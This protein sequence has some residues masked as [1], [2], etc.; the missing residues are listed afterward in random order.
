M[1]AERFLELVTSQT[2][3]LDRIMAVISSIDPQAPT[4]DEIVAALDELSEQ[5]DGTTPSAAVASVFGGRG[6]GGLGFSGNAANYYD[7]RNSMIHHVLDR[8]LGIPLTL[9]VVAVEVARRNGIALVAI[10]MPGHVLLGSTDGWHDPFAAGAPLDL[11]GCKRIFH[12]I[13]PDAPFLDH[14]LQPMAEAAIAGRTLE[15]LRVAGMG[16]GDLAQLA[17]VLELRA[18][19]PGAPVDHRMEY[20]RA[21]E[22]LGRYDLAAEQRDV[23]AGL[24][25]TRSDHH[26]AQAVRLRTHR[27]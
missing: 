7:A 11:E 20:A 1:T 17:A 21:L 3:S 16:S 10:G 4:E 24:L 18:L 26:L 23:L 9:A 14:Y 6:A 5:V 12:T 2:P 25:P 15:N 27:N 19:I 22:V 13:H 8:R